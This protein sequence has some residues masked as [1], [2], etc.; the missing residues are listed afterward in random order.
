MND[1]TIENPAEPKTLYRF[2]W[3]CGRM[4]EVSG[5]FAATKAQIAN[6]LGKQVYLGEVLGKHSEIYGDLDESDL[7]ELTSDATFIA[8]AERFKCIPN[9]YNPLDYMEDAQ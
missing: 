6:A 7:T 2:H 9:G 5:I 1:Q 3:D 4:G 8:Q